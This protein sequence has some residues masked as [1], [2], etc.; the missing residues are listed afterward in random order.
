M[1]LLVCVFTQS[2]TSLEFLNF[3]GCGVLHLGSN[4]EEDFDF[5]PAIKHWMD[6]GE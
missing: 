6:F 5:E 2:F 3:N 4:L 1:C